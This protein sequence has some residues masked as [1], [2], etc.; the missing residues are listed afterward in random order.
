M[1]ITSLT[2]RIKQKRSRFLK[3]IRRSPPIINCKIVDRRLNAHQKAIADLVLIL[4]S[5]EKS[6]L[7]GITRCLEYYTENFLRSHH[8]GVLY[9]NILNKILIC[10]NIW[11]VSL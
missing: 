4:F 8:L 2:F 9:R 3:T 5:G 6:M 11:K 10:G 7:V 1:G